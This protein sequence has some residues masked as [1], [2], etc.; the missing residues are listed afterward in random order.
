MILIVSTTFWIS[1]WMLWKC[2]FLDIDLILDFK[3]PAWGRL[4]L[5]HASPHLSKD[6]IYFNHVQIHQKSDKIFWSRI[7]ILLNFTRVMAWMSF[8][9]SSTRLK[10]FESKKYNWW[11]VNSKILLYCINS[12]LIKYALQTRTVSYEL[13]RIKLNT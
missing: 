8:W 13:K 11:D 5:I 4:S 2:S 1:S 10:W 7:R 12:C 6:L 9:D 3:W